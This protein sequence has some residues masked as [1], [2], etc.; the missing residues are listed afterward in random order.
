VIELA[1]K[2]CCS[3]L[4]GSILG[5][6]VLGRRRGVDIRTLGSGNA[7]STNA[8]RT[9]GKRFA[10][11]VVII[12][13]GKGW[14]ATQ[15]I[16]GA[17][18]GLPGDPM[19]HAWLPAACGVAAMLGHVYP[20]WYGWRGGKAVATFFG[21][22]CG[23][24]PLLLVPVLLVWLA[25]TLLTGF[26]SL[27]SM[28]AALLSPAIVLLAGLSWRSP[29]FAFAVCAALLVLFAHRANLRRLCKRCEPRALRP[30]HLKA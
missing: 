1:C 6:L 19:L 21:A 13:A 9:Q 7:G 11:G 29:L 17:P 5:S 20:V 28:C 22:L 26:V 3:Y 25:V 23:L 27:A 12:D 4:L 30:W 10:L 8:L 2:L 24:A 16:A 15:V 14:I 18:L